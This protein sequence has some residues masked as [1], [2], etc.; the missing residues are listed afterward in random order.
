MNLQERTL[1]VLACKYVN[2]VVIGAPFSV[3]KNLI[4]HFNVQVVCN[5]QTAI[6]NDVGQMDPYAI[7]KAMG[8]FVLIDSGNDMSTKKIVDRI[9]RNRLEYEARNV[10]KEKKEIE[11][12]E[13]IQKMNKSA[14]KCV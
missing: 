8:K 13:T 11:V 4:E 1:S 3:T 7:P 9:I 14:E 5:G 6:A 10:K 2:E 12:Y